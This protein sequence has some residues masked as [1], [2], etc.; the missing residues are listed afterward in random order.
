MVLYAFEFPSVQARDMLY[1][2]LAIQ[3]PTCLV[4]NPHFSECMMRDKAQFL[5]V[6]IP[7]SLPSPYFFYTGFL[8]PVEVNRNDDANRRY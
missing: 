4:I 2:A 7:I 3:S 5:L 8:S 6:L 1:Q